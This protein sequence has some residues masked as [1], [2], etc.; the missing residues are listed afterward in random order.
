[1]MVEKN[2]RNRK[3]S[4]GPQLTTGKALGARGPLTGRSI[5]GLAFWGSVWPAARWGPEWI[6]VGSD[7]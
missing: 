2:L 6:P 1:M 4:P 3:C 5:T 7:M